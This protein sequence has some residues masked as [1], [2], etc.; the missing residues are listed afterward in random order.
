[1]EEEGL[2]ERGGEEGQEGRGRSMK[3]LMREYKEDRGGSRKRIEKV[4][5]GSE[6]EGVVGVRSGVERYEHAPSILLYSLHIF[7]LFLFSVSSLSGKKCNGK[8]L[9][10]AGGITKCAKTKIF[11]IVFIL[12]FYIDPPYILHST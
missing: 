10:L 12:H 7:P 6:K 2:E 9:Q 5:R 8:S 4:G 3:G 1:M 11:F